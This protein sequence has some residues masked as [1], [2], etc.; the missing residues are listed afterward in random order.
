MRK[1]AFVL[2]ALST[3]LG[4]AL[5]QSRDETAVVAVSIDASSM[6]PWLSTNIT[7]KNVVSHLFDTLLARD[8]D[9]TIQP[10]VATSWQ[11]L[12]DT[13]WEFTLRD[14]V[15]FTNGQPLTAEDV[16]YTVEHF[17]DPELNAPSIA[18]FAPIASVEAVDATTVRFTTS[19]PFPA[20]PAVLTE[21]WIVPE[22]YT[23]EVGGQGL[24]QDPVGSGP[25]LL[26][27][28]VRDDHILLRANSD[29]WGGAPQVPFVEFRIVPDQ[30]TRIAQM[31]TGEADLVASVPAEAAQVLERVD[32]VEVLQAPNPRAYFLGFNQRLDT[33]LQDARVRQAVNYAINVDEILEFIFDG[34]GSP[35]ATLVTPQ[36]FGYDPTVE[37]FGYDPDR[38]RALLAEAGY[39]DGFSIRMEA[40]QAR[41]PKDAEVAQA[42]AA[43]LGQVGID[44]E[45]D[46][47]EWGTYIGQFR[48]ED[49]PPIYFLGWSIPTFDPDSI[50]TPLLTEGVTY[51][52]FVDDELASLIDRA[53]STVDGEARSELYGRIQSRMKELAPMAFLY[54]LDELYAVRDRLDWQPRADERIYLW[55]A[56]L[57]E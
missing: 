43:Q 13:T 56:S 49:G 57:A 52:R 26:E 12:D 27:E 29:W 10:N 30:N 1:A 15:E 35:L 2:L 38:A 21:F 50:L 42:I 40:P 54:Q 19:E 53:R 37:P 6:N 33:P 18:Q 3:L 48:A 55:N 51:S 24:G 39:P 20:L 34:K 5:S 8:L 7:D 22:G 44:V 25:Y 17:R 28:W 41:Y 46:I 14:D 23:T 32:G 11:A 16:A 47:Q 9:M 36:Q 45:L 4:T 31:Q